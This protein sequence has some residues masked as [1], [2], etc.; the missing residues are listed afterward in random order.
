MKRL[1]LIAICCLPVALFAQSSQTAT[2]YIARRI[3]LPLLDAPQPVPNASVSV[4]GNPGPATY[5]YWIVTNGVAGAS[6]PAGPFQVLNAPNTLSGSNFN[7]ISWA[8]VLGAVS[9]D[10][11]RTSTPGPPFGAC[12]CAVATAVAG[13]TTN[14]QA[15]ALNAYTVNTFD[16]STLLMTITHESLGSGSSNLVFRSGGA[17]IF[18]IS[19][20]GA[21][22]PSTFNTG[23]GT[24]N[25]IPKFTNGPSGVIGNSGIMDDGTTETLT[26]NVTATAGQNLLKSYNF[27]SVIWLDGIK[28]TSLSA[29]YAAIP[30]ATYSACGDGIGTCWTGGGGVVE[31]PPGWIDPAWAANLVLKN[32][33]S[34]HFNGPAYF[35]QGTFQVTMASGVHGVTIRNDMAADHSQRTS[36]VTFDYS[37]SGSAWAIGDSGGQVSNIIIEN[38]QIHAIGAGVAATALDLVSPIYSQFLDLDLVCP[39]NSANSGFG[40]RYDGL[41]VSRNQNLFRGIVPNFCNHPVQFK[42][43]ASGNIWMGG[44]PTCSGGSACT[45]PSANPVFDIQGSSSSNVFIGVAEGPSAGSFASFFNFSGTASGN[46]VWAD[47]A[48]P[49]VFVTTTV[50]FGGST[51][52]NIFHCLS[53]GCTGTPGGI[54]NQMLDPANVAY[55]RQVGATAAIGFTTILTAPSAANQG[56]FI[57]I[58]TACDTTGGGGAD[59]RVSIKYTDVSNTVQTL[60]NL[61][62]SSCTAL[63]ATS[64]ASSSFP[65]IAKAG[66]A[67]QYSTTVTAVPTYDL[68]I[69]VTPSGLN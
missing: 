42:G 57:A 23:T 69:S 62:I 56:Y 31:V 48:A 54:G 64:T 55:V 1:L 17:K 19:S 21:I 13:N 16:P 46:E 51:S 52:N 59:T 39:S 10:V 53:G 2:D 5:F 3:Q 24:T 9:F 6:S 41:A 11:L 15:N 34:I 35:N 27:N 58:A 26:G 63:G 18:T 40:L 67:V 7:R 14:D 28:Y 20:A 50:V 65:I 43:Q 12:N 29:A 25:S 49:G 32:N 60:A 36:G 33:A 66:T 61:A 68:R 38:I 30:T 44:I 47:N 45:A 22:G 4:S 37:G 8:N